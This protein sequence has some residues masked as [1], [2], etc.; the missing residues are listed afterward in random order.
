MT[1]KQRFLGWSLALAGSAGLGYLIV[2]SL[3]AR[4][5]D[6]TI[7]V[8]GMPG[9]LL[10][11]LVAI[12]ALAF[13]THVATGRQRQRIPAPIKTARPRRKS[14]AAASSARPGGRR[15]H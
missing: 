2:Q 1:L 12:I 14:D 9:D 8:T 5:N 11:G 15:G 10:L 6:R 4:L 3:D 7:Y 13:G